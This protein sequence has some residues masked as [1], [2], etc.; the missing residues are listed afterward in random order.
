MIQSKSTTSSDGLVGNSEASA[1][2]VSCFVVTGS[3]LELCSCSK[4][5]QLQRTAELQ[6]SV[7][8]FKRVMDITDIYKFTIN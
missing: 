6:Q 4:W 3:V 8:P 7:G 2:P 1:L 5:H